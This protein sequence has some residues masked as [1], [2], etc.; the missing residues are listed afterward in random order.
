MGYIMKKPGVALI[1]EADTGRQ[2]ERPLWKIDTG[3]RL[4]SWRN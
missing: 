2:R 1:D 4:N 3:R